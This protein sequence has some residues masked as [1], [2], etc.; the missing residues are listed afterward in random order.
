MFLI[1]IVYKSFIIMLQHIFVN[2]KPFNL[3]FLHGAIVWQN[4]VVSSLP[5]SIICKNLILYY[6]YMYLV[7]S[8]KYAKMKLQNKYC[9]CA[10][11]GSKA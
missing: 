8:S 11:F 2:N 1:L 7:V 9:A 5:P 3:I 4:F 6:I 10:L